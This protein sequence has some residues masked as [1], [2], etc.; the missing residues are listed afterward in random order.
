MV[1]IYRHIGLNGSRPSNMWQS[2]QCLGWFRNDSTYIDLP[3][4]KRPFFEV[5][6]E[7]YTVDE[8]K[9]KSMNFPSWCSIFR[10]EA[11]HV[12]LVDLATCSAAI[13][14]QFGSQ[15]YGTWRIWEVF[16]EYDMYTKIRY[17]EDSNPILCFLIWTQCPGW[18]HSQ[19]STFH[20]LDYG[21]KECRENLGRRFE[22]SPFWLVSIGGYPIYIGFFH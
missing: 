18:L 9:G 20:V 7:N 12:Q 14:D 16:G 1:D 21:S 17:T 10:K 3:Q 8:L 13:A 11:N 22:Q 4:F 19:L 15:K 2:L 5:V 6:W